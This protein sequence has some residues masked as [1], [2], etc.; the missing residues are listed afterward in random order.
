MMM[1]SKFA[2]QQ[3]KKVHQNTGYHT[4]KIKNKHDSDEPLFAKIMEKKRS[5]NQSNSFVASANR[6]KA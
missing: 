4:M 5:Y 3:T 1:S 6:I 2:V